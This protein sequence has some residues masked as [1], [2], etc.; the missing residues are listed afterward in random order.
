M[1]TI[2]EAVH[3]LLRSKGNKPLIILDAGLS[4]ESNY[5]SFLLWRNLV[6]VLDRHAQTVQYM[7]DLEGELR[8]VEPAVTHE[9]DFLSARSNMALTDLI[10]VADALIL[11]RNS[12][13]QNYDSKLFAKPRIILGNLSS[14][15]EC[16]RVVSNPRDVLRIL[17][18]NDKIAG[19]FADD[20]EFEK[21]CKAGGINPD[22]WGY[23]RKNIRHLLWHSLPAGV[24][25]GVGGYFIVRAEVG[26]IG[27]TVVSALS[28]VK[29]LTELHGE[30]DN[31][32][33]D[34]LIS[35]YCRRMQEKNPS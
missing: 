10:Y 28:G 31:A 3:E 33:H 17:F 20:P 24:L 4:Q 16:Y 8:V 35:F 29:T 5:E 23:Y 19:H 11:H 12:V 9:L 2:D 13:V 15:P 32:M 14:P 30:H 34:A 22:I 7:S 1:G 25:A 18:E 27:G 21:Y 26:I 6:K